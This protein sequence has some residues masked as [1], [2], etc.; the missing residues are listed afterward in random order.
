MPCGLLV[1][2]EG[3]LLLSAASGGQMNA[4]VVVYFKR[5]FEEVCSFC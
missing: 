1:A 4:I 2:G 3:Q 5:L